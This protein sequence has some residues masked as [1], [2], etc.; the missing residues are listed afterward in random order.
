MTKK[1]KENLRRKWRKWLLKNGQYLGVLLTS[2]DVFEEVAR[3][4]KTNTK[5]QSPA[6]YHRWLNNNYL[7]SV[8]T[9]IRRLSDRSRKS[10]S[11][12][13][14]IEDMSRHPAVITRDYFTSTYPK[15]MR[16][17]GLADYDYDRFA[18]KKSNVLSVPR[19][20]KDLSRLKRE[21]ARVKTFTDKWIAHLDLDRKKFKR[22]T[23]SNISATLKHLD[24]LYC[25]YYLLLTRGGMTTCKPVLQY[26]W[27]TPL[28]YPW[29]EKNKTK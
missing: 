10:L 9:G 13:R 12:Y 24:E 7:S 27:R 11:L 28:R 8:S 22:P 26:D 5:I 6:L 3:I 17:E 23:Y 14:L 19:L 21:T 2:H 20:K 1:E 16:K 4:V 18:T 25:R 15:W 29:I